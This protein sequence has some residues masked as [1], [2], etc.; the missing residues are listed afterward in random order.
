MV[1]TTEELKI[2]RM[3]KE[4]LVMVLNWATL[5]GAEPGIYDLETIYNSDP[6]GFFV[7]EIDNQLVGSSS[8]VR[9]GDDFGFFGYW[10]V[11]PEFRNKKIGYKLIKQSMDYFGNRNVG[12]DGVQ[13][14]MNNFEKSGF[15]T[16]FKNIR[17]S[18]VVTDLGPIP[19]KTIDLRNFD[20]PELLA[21]DSVMFG[22][23]RS[24]FLKMWIDQPESKALGIVENGKIRGYG[25]LRPCPNSYKI[26]PLFA[27]NYE[28]AESLFNSLVDGIENVP[29]IMD[30]PEPN[31]DALKLAKT[32]G[33]NKYFELTR[34]YT[35]EPLKL[36]L[37]RIFAIT[38]PELG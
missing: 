36:P 14:Q 3:T 23:P 7:A 33:L 30:I 20:F 31:K 2:R 34:M 19:Y 26:G 22:V 25:V 32:Y 13:E 27:D 8:S 12:L 1:I 35:G 9:Y 29:I 21:Y 6:E 24:K 5:G 4:D 15:K 37:N 16:A 18:G 28:I 10:I 17:F 38:T 11:L